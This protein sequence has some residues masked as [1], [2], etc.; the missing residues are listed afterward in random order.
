M[1]GYVER[2]DGSALLGREMGLGK[3]GVV[4]AVIDA[5]PL[6]GDVD[7]L[8]YGPSLVKAHRSPSLL[9]LDLNIET[10]LL[11]DLFASFGLGNGFELGRL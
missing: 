5:Q 8:P 7:A 2:E 11:W 3:G 9:R 6:A 10:S 4:V 1:D